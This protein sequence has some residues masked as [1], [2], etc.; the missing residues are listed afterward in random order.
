[1]FVSCAAHNLNLGV[2][3]A[4]KEVIK[5]KHFLKPCNKFIILLGAV[6]KDL[7]LRI[8]DIFSV[9]KKVMTLKLISD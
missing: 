8:K 3:D 9:V 2:I 5:R 6:S 7:R 1:M 4:V